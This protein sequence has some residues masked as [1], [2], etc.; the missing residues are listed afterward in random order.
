MRIIPRI[1]PIDSKQLIAQRA[2]KEVS[3]FLYT[4]HG[5]KLNGSKS[6]CCRVLRTCIMRGCNDS[7]TANWPAAIKAAW[8]QLISSF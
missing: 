6:A 5:H 4:R 7:Q 3:Y 2:I 1:F 8:S